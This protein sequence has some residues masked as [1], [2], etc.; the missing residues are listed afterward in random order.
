MEYY[1]RL[2]PDALNDFTM[3]VIAFCDKPFLH[4]EPLHRLAFNAALERDIDITRVII[5]EM[6]EHLRLL[7]AL[8]GFRDRAVLEAEV[9]ATS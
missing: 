2:R 4:P 6:Q 3:A 1:E 8:K 7:E 5:R 9:S